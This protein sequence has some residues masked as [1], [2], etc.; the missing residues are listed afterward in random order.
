MHTIK[1]LVI[2]MLFSNIALGAT[3]G[4]NIIC[5]SSAFKKTLNISVC[6]KSKVATDGVEI[7]EAIEQKFS[8]LTSSTITI[9]IPTL[10]K[11]K[12]DLQLKELSNSRE[13]I[14]E[15]NSHEKLPLPIEGFETL[16][17]S[18]NSQVILNRSLKSLLSKPL[19][20][21][22][23]YE[24]T[25]GYTF[26]VQIGNEKISSKFT[27]ASEWS[28]PYS[29]FSYLRLSRPVHPVPLS[30]MITSTEIVVDNKK[31][32]ANLTESLRLVEI[33]SCANLDDFLQITQTIK[34]TSKG[35]VIVDFFSNDTIS[36]GYILL[37]EHDA[38]ILR[39]INSP[40]NDLKSLLIFPGQSYIFSYK[41]LDIRDISELKGNRVNLLAA[42]TVRP[43]HYFVNRAEFHLSSS[44]SGF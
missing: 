6:L 33:Y 2:Y 14:F 37:R 25:I 10:S 35:S 7:F 8:N 13:E 43:W 34:N 38:T 17:I 42:Y 15:T 44:I 3:S 19:Q 16:A 23:P 4:S 30:G 9:F 32:I 26:G 28:K 41:L 5:D 18:A 31:C 11:S 22:V 39:S 29:I 27:K 1:S 40:R 20:S 12:T 36:P 21:E 24:L